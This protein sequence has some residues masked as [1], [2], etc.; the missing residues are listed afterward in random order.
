MNKLRCATI[1]VAVLLNAPSSHAFSVGDRYDDVEA[2]LKAK[3]ASYQLV[4]LDKDHRI[5]VIG[6]NQIVVVFHGDLAIATIARFT[7]PRTEAEL[8]DFRGEGNWSPVVPGEMWVRSNDGVK[9]VYDRKDYSVTFV[10][11]EGF[12]F[13]NQLPEYIR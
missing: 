5:L 4:S 7:E 11:S 8:K 3:N 10:N 1:I 6:A 2:A 12:K 9:F 13:L